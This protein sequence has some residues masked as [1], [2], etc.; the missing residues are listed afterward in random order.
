MY[1]CIHVYMLRCIHV[2]MLRCVYIHRYFRCRHPA[3]VPPMPGFRRPPFRSSRPFRCRH[4]AQVPSVLR[5][6][7]FSVACIRH[8]YRPFQVSNDSYRP[9]QFPAIAFFRTG[10]VHRLGSVILFSSLR[11]CGFPPQFCLETETVV[12]LS[13][14]PADMACC[15]FFSFPYPPAVKHE[16]GPV[17]MREIVSFLG[18][19]LGD[20]GRGRE[21]CRRAS[22]F[23]RL[24][25]QPVTFSLIEFASKS[26]T[27]MLKNLCTVGLMNKSGRVYCAT[28]TNLI[29]SWTIQ[30][31]TE[32]NQPP[33]TIFALLPHE[34]FN[35]LYSTTPAL[36][37]WLMGSEDTLRDWWD[38]ARNVGGSWYDKHSVIRDTPEATRRIPLGLHG[39]DAGMIGH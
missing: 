16:P 6:S 7:P 27:V 13:C 1:T 30:V 3:P 11:R 37:R 39:D 5:L 4:P 23:A 12:F 32:P 14:I 22:H 28:Y 33:L 15:F 9:F 21:S 8:R 19:L 35:I 10:K 20:I 24:A 36:F 31:T 25:L 2:Y 38:G 34:V 17:D 26:P 18:N 29:S